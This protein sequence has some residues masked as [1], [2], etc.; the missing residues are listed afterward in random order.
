[1]TR[2]SKEIVDL[3]SLQ[4]GVGRSLPAISLC[5]GEPQSISVI[6]KA[7][8]W[9][10][11]SMS[12]QCSSGRHHW[13]RSDNYWL[14][15]RLQMKHAIYCAR[16]M[17]SF[18]RLEPKQRCLANKIKLGWN[19]RKGTD[20]FKGFK[21]KKQMDKMWLQMWLQWFEN[22]LKQ[23]IVYALLTI[24]TSAPFVWHIFKKNVLE[25][26]YQKIEISL[27]SLF[28]FFYISF[29]RNLFT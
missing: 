22:V 15:T 6:Q 16:C 17:L 23:T 20:G 18:E 11:P 24:S 8:D 28:M 9:N 5:H 4:P 10:T 21:P 29:Y 19:E 12:T 26:R 7:S 1:M 3:Y 27:H 25:T 14:H 2:R 13:L